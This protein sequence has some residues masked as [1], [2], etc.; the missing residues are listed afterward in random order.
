MDIVL[1]LFLC[2]FC[3]D[4]CTNYAFNQEQN[5]ISIQNEQNINTENLES[6]PSFWGDKL[7]FMYSGIK[8]K[9]FDTR[10]DEPFF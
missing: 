2:Q 10:I 7:T 5:R 6:S 8:E 9:I 4:K 3:G 1:G